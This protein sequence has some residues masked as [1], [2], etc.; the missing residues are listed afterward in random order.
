[1]PTNN[2]SRTFCG[3]NCPLEGGSVEDNLCPF[4]D[5]CAAWRDEMAFDRLEQREKME[6]LLKEGH[7]F[8]PRKA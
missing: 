5:Q 6:R 4:I 7:T 8:L 3:K 1:M 2:D